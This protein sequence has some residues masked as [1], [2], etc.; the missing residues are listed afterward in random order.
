LLT[1]P[2]DHSVDN[3]KRE[4]QKKKKKKKKI[5]STMFV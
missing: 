2:V 3:G 1:L 5:T 4:K